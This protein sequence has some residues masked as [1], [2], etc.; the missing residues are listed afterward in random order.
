MK[1]LIISLSKIESS[2]QTSQKVY[3]QLIDY[4]LDAELFEGTYGNEVEDIFTK[5]NRK[6]AEIGFKGV[7]TD[8]RYQAKC[9]RLGVKGCFHS[10]Y[11]AWEYCLKLGEPIL[12]FEDDVIFYRNFIPIEWDEILMLATGKNLFEDDYFKRILLE[13]EGEPKALPLK[14]SSMPGT[15]V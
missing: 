2:F 5:E 9:N 14:K 12:I 11:R 13:P 3:Q 4:G 7:S 10:H 15:V 8:P 6:L 1:S